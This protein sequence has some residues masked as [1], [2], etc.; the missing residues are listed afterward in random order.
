MTAALQHCNTARPNC[1]STAGPQD[2]STKF[3]ELELALGCHSAKNAIFYE[4]QVFSVDR[5]PFIGYFYFLREAS[6]GLLK[7]KGGRKWQTG[8]L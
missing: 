3:G 2:S 4:E 7:T 1:R 5:V 6:N 8:M